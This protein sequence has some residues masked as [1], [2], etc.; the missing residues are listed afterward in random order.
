MQTL[1]WFHV[2]GPDVE[3]YPIPNPQIRINKV[4]TTEYSRCLVLHPHH[5]DFRR[6]ST[7]FYCGFPATGLAKQKKMLAH[8]PKPLTLTPI[9]LREISSVPDVFVPSR[10][11]NF[12]EER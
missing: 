10:M 7:T 8:V 2:W 5:F 12:Q 6:E 3:L 4:V 11:L 9:F 1:T